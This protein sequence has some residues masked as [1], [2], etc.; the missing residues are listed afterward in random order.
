VVQLEIDARD[1]YSEAQFKYTRTRITPLD[2][3]NPRIFRVTTRHGT[4][5]FWASVK[6]YVFKFLA[7]VL[8]KSEIYLLEIATGSFFK[9]PNHAVVSAPVTFRSN[10]WERLEMRTVLLPGVIVFPS[11]SF[12]YSVTSS[13]SQLLP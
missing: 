6:S 13:L 10:I 8:W 4:S 7:T 12:C 1:S 3:E 9:L 11:C 2:S 5:S